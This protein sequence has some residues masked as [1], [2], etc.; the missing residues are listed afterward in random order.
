MMHSW[1]KS[2]TAT[3]ITGLSCSTLTHNSYV[4]IDVYGVTATYI[5]EYMYG[6]IRYFWQGNRPITGRNG[7][8]TVIYG[9]AGVTKHG[10]LSCHCGQCCSL[11]AYFCLFARQLSSFGRHG[12]IQMLVPP[13]PP[14]K[15]GDA[16]NTFYNPCQWCLR[17]LLLYCLTTNHSYVHP[18]GEV[19]RLL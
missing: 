18:P 8:Y 11:P 16:H 9:T 4:C 1:H 10:S 14:T 2:M 13:W 3:G 5:Y 17:Y 6:V 19:M 12:S 15:M 7:S